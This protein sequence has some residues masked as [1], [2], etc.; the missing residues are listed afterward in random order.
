[1]RV[2]LRATGR[3]LLAAV[4]AGV[5]VLAGLPAWSAPVTRFQMP[6]PC[7]QEWTGKSRDNHSPSK[8]AIDF[9]RPDDAGDDVVAAAPGVVTVVK[10]RSGGYGNYVRVEHEN[11][12][13]SLYAHLASI[14]VKE[15]QALDQA[16][17][18]GTV[19]KSG[20]ATGAHLHFE[21]RNAKGTVVA[22][23]FDGV[24]FV[25]GS[26]LES[27]NCVDVP[28]A[29]NFVGNRAAEVGVF[30]RRSAA[31]FRIPRPNKGPK[32]IRLGT[33]T[34]QPVVGD[35]DGNGRVNPGV[36]TPSTRRFTLKSPLGIQ[37]IRFGAAADRP[38][39]GDWDGDGRW[40]VGVVK[41]GTNRFR[42]RA[43][44][45]KVT[46]VYLGDVGD[47]PVTGDWDGDGVTDLGVYDQAAAVF[48]LRTVD[49]DGIVWLADVPFGSP[50]D[51]PVVG[52]WD[53][54][55]ITDVGVWDPGTAVF[56]QRR[57]KRPVGARVVRERQLVVG[58]PR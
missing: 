51:L 38:I 26:S 48:T 39:A 3:A 53:G 54:N 18:V 20:N 5:V 19:G 55:G 4:L 22:A 17:L 35:W 15:G 14:V 30:R 12:E 23:F 46:P 9:N 34:D 2:P 28:V 45:K 33:G 49:A 8:R 40:E 11:G 52:D 44:D 10:R 36:R 13:E 50:G 41:T 37:S 47:L 29:G 57:A 24:K 7:G 21:E 32:V 31:E 16:T 42:L 6:F 25:M 43:A 1:M 58:E 56:T 27:R